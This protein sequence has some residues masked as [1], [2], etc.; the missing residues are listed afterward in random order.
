MKLS[1]FIEQKVACTVVS[2]EEKKDVESCMRFGEYQAQRNEIELV[3]KILEI[4]RLPWSDEMKDMPIQKKLESGCPLTKDD[5]KEMCARKRDSRSSEEENKRIEVLTEYFKYE[6]S[7]RA[8]LKWLDIESSKKGA[9]I[10]ENAW[11]RKLYDVKPYRVE[12]Y[13][14]KNTHK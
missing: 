6:V 11:V 13:D 5:F 2:K 1:G 14:L 9:K 7:F 12:Q 10:I 3:E 4:Q 8:E